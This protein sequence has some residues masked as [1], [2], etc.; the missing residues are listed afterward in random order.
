MQKTVLITKRGQNLRHQIFL[1][2]L[3]KGLTN[4]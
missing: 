4:E 1:N 3:I 2:K